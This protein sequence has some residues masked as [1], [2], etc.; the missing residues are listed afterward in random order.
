VERNDNRPRHNNPDWAAYP[1]N[2]AVMGTSLGQLYERNPA[3]T[4]CHAR[5]AGAEL[6]Y[7][8]IVL[9]QGMQR[10][11]VGS[12]SLPDDAYVVFMPMLLRPINDKLFQ[13]SEEILFLHQIK[14][15]IR[16]SPI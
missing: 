15:W 8:P 11:G 4:E 2:A 16:L 5:L 10:V 12:F 14:H 9:W 3:R 1:G 6:P 13:A 7:R